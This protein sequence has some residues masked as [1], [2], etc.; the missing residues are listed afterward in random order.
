MD[1]A[2]FELLANGASGFAWPGRLEFD[3][4]DEFGDAAEVFFVVGFPSEVFDR[5]GN[6]RVRLLLFRC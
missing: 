1:A 2:V 5:N 4:F 3:D 6:R